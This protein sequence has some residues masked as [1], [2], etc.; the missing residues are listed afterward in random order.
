MTPL[1]FQLRA[2]LL[3]LGAAAPIVLGCAETEPASEAEIAAPACNRLSLASVPADASFVLIVND[4]MRRDR[5]GIYGGA[6]RTPHFD[7][8]AREGLL[9]SRTIAPAQP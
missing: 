9:F 4:A 7:A 3:L 8:F 2:T 1:R 5:A 6:A